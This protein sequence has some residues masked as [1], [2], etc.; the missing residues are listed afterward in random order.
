[1]NAAVGLS[2]VP[3]AT[4]VAAAPTAISSVAGTNRPR[5]AN[6]PTARRFTDLGR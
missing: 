5:P 1:M 3:V 2:A 6:T 4:L